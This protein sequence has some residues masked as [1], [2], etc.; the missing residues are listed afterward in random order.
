MKKKESNSK[1]DKKEK[2]LE[3]TNGVSDVLDNRVKKNIIAVF[4]IMLALV[5]LL[6][7]F[8]L[9]GVVGEYIDNGLSF[10]FGWGRFLLPM[11][12][13]VLGALYFRKMEPIRYTLAA[14]GAVLFFVMFLGF[15]HIFKDLDTMVVVSK[16]GS[17]GGYVGLAMAYPLARFLG[18]IAG[19]IILFGFSLIGL[20]LIFNMSVSQLW[21]KLR[22]QAMPDGETDE[23]RSKFVEGPKSEKEKKEKEKE[24]EQGQDEEEDNIKID[25]IKYVEG[26][27]DEE[28]LVREKE[29]TVSGVGT[30][31]ENGEAKKNIFSGS[32]WKQPPTK[33]FAKSKERP[34]QG[35]LEENVEIIKNTLGDFGIEVAP[36]EYHIGPTVTQYTFKPAVGVKLSK[37]VALQNDLALALAAQ[38]IRIEAPIPG[39]SL[40]GVE[41]PNKNKSMVRM[42]SMLESD[43]FKNKPSKLSVVLGEDVNG[44]PVLANIEKMP[45]ML[46]A[47]ATNTGK[48]IGINALLCTLLCENSP[49]NLRLILVDPKR[50]ELSVYEGIPHLLTPVIVDMDRVVRTLKWA[51]SEMARRYKVLQEMGSRDIQSYNGKVASG[52]KKKVTDKETGK[53]KRVDLEKM[54]Y[55]LIVIDEL[56]DLMA[57]HGRDVEGL[58]VQLAQMAR[59][60]GIHLIISTQRPSVEVITGLIK[61]NIITRVAFQV[62]SQIDSRTIL[63]MSGAEKLLGNGDLLFLNAE[64]PQPRR[65]QGIYVSESEVKKL[66]R[67]IKKQAKKIDFKESE[68]LS[69]SLEGDLENETGI[70]SGTGTEGDGDEELYAQAKE[71]VLQANKASTSMLQRRLKIGYSR[72]ARIVDMLEEQGVVGPAEGAKAREVLVGSQSDPGYEEGE[73]IDDQEKREK[74]NK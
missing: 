14:I 61:A 22:A 63:D 19:V 60:V 44:H 15:V 45:H 70:F 74:W 7:L 52:K 57:T 20:M 59:A 24:G 49:E 30:G 72:A 13:I 32:G 31:L 21:A 11:V 39:K 50:V 10:L 34:H 8:G 4:L 43:V 27:Q 47:G 40:V 26:P 3:K 65:I 35:N 54:P 58:V 37:I 71:V 55:I 6:S 5:M 23:E 48:S 25:T 53:E 2:D 68:D 9:A 41:V 17:G 62:R 1:K 64:S 28:A 12:M 18:K 29:V 66:V 51:I 67:F 36:G 73:E 46:I 69:N 16:A 42:R 33:I 38:A 56:S